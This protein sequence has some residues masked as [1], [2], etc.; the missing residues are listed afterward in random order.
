MFCFKI[1]FFYNHGLP[2]QILLYFILI[3][4][5]FSNQGLS[6]Q[7]HTKDMQYF[8]WFEENFKTN[9]YNRVGKKKIKAYK[10]SVDEFLVAI[11]KKLG[12][13]LLSYKIISTFEKK[14]SPI[15][16]INFFWYNNLIV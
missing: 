13:Y 1:V 7:V 9:F 8:H 11:A 2:Y 14:G 6:Y 5:F 10:N 4:L 16:S 12:W 3:V 15:N